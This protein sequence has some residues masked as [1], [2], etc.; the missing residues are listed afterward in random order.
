MPMRQAHER[1]PDP[2]CPHCATMLKY[3]GSSSGPAGAYR[4]QEPGKR[5]IVDLDHYACPNRGCLKLWKMGPD[6]K[7]VTDPVGLSRH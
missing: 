2:P 4:K 1:R 5:A 7:L 3:T 6:F